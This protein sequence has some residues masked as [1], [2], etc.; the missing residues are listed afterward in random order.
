[1]AY[2]F[3][4]PTV[5]ETPAGFG[6]LFWRF[7]IARSDTLL[8]Y[9]NN[10]LSVRTPGVDQTQEADYCYQGGHVYVLTA[11]EITI[12]TNAGYG[13]YITNIPDSQFKG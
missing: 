3:N 12:L 1:M 6:R 2:V 10:V 5:D 8:V 4:P 13:A 7:R 9:G 11:P